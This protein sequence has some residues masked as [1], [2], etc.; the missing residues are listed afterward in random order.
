MEILNE[1]LLDVNLRETHI[2]AN[3]QA[4]DHVEC[5]QTVIVLAIMLVIQC[6]LE[7]AK[8]YTSL[9]YVAG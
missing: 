7:R 8:E 5:I 6:N 9:L 4:L 1:K 2:S 3:F